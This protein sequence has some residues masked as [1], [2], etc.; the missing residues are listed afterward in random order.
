MLN[1]YGSAFKSGGVEIRAIQNV[2]TVVR[3]PAAFCAVKDF[4]PTFVAP[5]G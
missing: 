1:P 4:D 2:D 3:R 5:A